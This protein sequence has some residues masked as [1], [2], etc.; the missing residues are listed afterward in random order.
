MSARQLYR[1][2][3]DLH[4]YLGLFVSPFILLFAVSVFFLNH[5]KILSRS[6]TT[7]SETFHDVRVPEGIDRLQ[8]LAAVTRA[9][10]ILPQIG[11]TG[12]IGF[13]RVLAKEQHLVFP[14]SKPGV[15]ATVDVDIAARSA[16]VTRRA[17]SQTAG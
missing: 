9:R 15:E 10:E 1:W 17:T 5:G 4:L 14:V 12:E 13:L 7:S 8:G 11:L 2:T 3:R 6:Q 16:L